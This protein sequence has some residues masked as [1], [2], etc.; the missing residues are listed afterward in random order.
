MSNY[1]EEIR[2][3]KSWMA[4]YNG[5]A[6][7]KGFVIGLSG[8]IDSSVVACLAVKAVGKENVIGISLPCGGTPDHY[9]HDAADL[10]SNLGIVFFTKS[11][12]QS[13]Q[14]INAD[15]QVLV[16]G[17]D[18]ED[19]SRLTKSNIKARLRMLYIYAMA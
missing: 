19:A 12:F 5:E 13:L 7:T 15:I 10:A 17:V 8:G 16:R 4:K 11:M 18:K 14:N 3:I 6:G 2:K 1:K 9:Q